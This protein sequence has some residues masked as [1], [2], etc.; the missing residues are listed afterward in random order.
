ML[1]DGRQSGAQHLSR[2]GIAGPESS[3]ISR[4]IVI[5]PTTA[6][7]KR[8]GPGFGDPLFF[9]MAQVLHDASRRRRV[10]FTGTATATATGSATGSASGSGQP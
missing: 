9:S 4:T 10:Q 7:D 2:C 1:G 3:Q 8:K 5:E 6:A